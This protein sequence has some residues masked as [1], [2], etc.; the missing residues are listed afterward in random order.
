M[1]VEWQIGDVR[2]RPADVSCL[3]LFREIDGVETG[4][5]NVTERSISTDARGR[6]FIDVPFL[7]N[8]PTGVPVRLRIRGLA[9]N[10]ETGE[11]CGVA[12]FFG[13]VGPI[14]FRRGERRVVQLRMY[15]L[16]TS[17]EVRFAEAG[18]RFLHTSTALPDGR[19]L[20]T[21]GFTSLAPANCP[22]EVPAESLCYRA[23]ASNSALLFIPGSGLLY[24][25]FGGMSEPRAGHT[26]TALADGRVLLI[27]G[28]SDAV[29]AIA[30]SGNTFEPFFV[31]ATAPSSTAEIFLPE[32]PTETQDLK[33]DGDPGRGSFVRISEERGLS[34]GRFLH[35]A[36]RLT[37]DSRVVVAGGISGAIAG[38][39]E[40]AETYE[41]FDELPGELPGFYRPEPPPNLNT[42][43]AWPAALSLGERTWV[44]GGALAPVSNEDLAETWIPSDGVGS[45]SPATTTTMTFPNLLGDPA[46]PRPEFALRRPA[47][48]AVEGEP[49]LGLVVGWLGPLCEAGTTNVRYFSPAS[50]TE[51]CGTASGPGSRSFVIDGD[52]GS[53]SALPLSEQHAFGT[54]TVLSNPPGLVDV[55]IAG[56]VSSE[57]WQ[58]SD[59]IDLLV[60]AGNRLDL[61]VS[62]PLGDARV[63][64]AA[65]PL[66]DGGLFVSGGLTFGP[67]RLDTPIAEQPITQPPLA[68]GRV[69]YL[70]LP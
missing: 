29:F 33:N 56:G 58:L 68:T 12:R 27:G 18:G 6:E 24:E 25:V 23:V 39:I 53:T 48:A 65:S 17:E 8:I 2:G 3:A 46:T 37:G 52:S 51:L 20:I 44:I 14:V 41:V 4:P 63:F 9:P 47:T 54:A 26:A 21:G 69:F 55:A 7:R 67:L 34:Q 36:A 28:V 32:T 40:V 13:S 62:R 61:V 42:S 11:V 66:L 70:V 5:T 16:D 59:Q 38:N 35:A 49:P 1:R 60:R 64:H 43:R 57:T 50:A 30:R 22:P 10:D 31:P 45:V 19:V 15:A